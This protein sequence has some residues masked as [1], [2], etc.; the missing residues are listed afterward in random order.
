MSHSAT[1]TPTHD[2]PVPQM[3]SRGVWIADFFDG[4][5][6]PVVQAVD[7]RHRVV[8]A[9]AW[10]KGQ[11]EEEITALLWSELDRLEPESEI[12]PERPPLAIVE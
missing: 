6:N 3:R 11:T 8:C 5:G 1:F 7:S 12:Q 4:Q 10:L 2:R 9:I